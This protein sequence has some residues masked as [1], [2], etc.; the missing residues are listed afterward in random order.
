MCG[1]VPPVSNTFRIKRR[2]PP[3]SNRFRPPSFPP[4]PR[5]VLP[6]DRHGQPIRPPP[7]QKATRN[8]VCRHKAPDGR[9]TT[10]STPIPVQQTSPKTRKK[11]V[12]R[13]VRTARRTFFLRVFGEVCCTGIGVELVV[14]RP[15]GALCRQTVFRVAFC[16]GGGRIGCP[17]RSGGR[18]VRG[19][20]G[21]DGGR[22][23]FESGG[24][25]LFIRKVFETGGTCPHIC[26]IIR[27]RGAVFDGTT[28]AYGQ[29]RF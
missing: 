20:G 2:T 16:G 4:P 21:K 23:R 24:V 17:C 15:S 11:N 7:P 19:G 8:T 1:Q 5:T 25:R 28:R 29:N 3:D 22:K 27:R 12:L 10:S 18:T 9:K 13:A 26:G 6:P 14:F